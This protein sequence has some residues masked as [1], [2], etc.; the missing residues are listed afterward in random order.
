MYFFTNSRTRGYLRGI[1]EEFGESTNAI[2]VELNRM[3]DAGLITSE[4]QG[5]KRIYAAN[6]EHPIYPEL[7]R[8]MHKS[9]GLDT[10]E[11]LAKALGTVKKALITGDYAKG[12]YTGII[13]L[14]LIGAIDRGALQHG[15]K[16]AEQT[17]ERRVRTLVLSTTEYD[18]YKTRFQEEEALVLYAP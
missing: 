5:R 9:L 8:I 13:D 2:R 17:L 12:S 18:Q 4:Q 11:T 15:V 16:E 10:L 7:S 3:Y 6:P 1:A 14:V